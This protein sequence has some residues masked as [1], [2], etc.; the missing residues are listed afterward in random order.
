MKKSG[1]RMRF[2]TDY[3]RVKQRFRNH[4]KYSKSYPEVDIDGGHNLV[5]MKCQFKFKK[6]K[7][8]TK[9]RRDMERLKR[10]ENRLAY[11]STLDTVKKD[12]QHTG[13][14][15]EKWERI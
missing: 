5:M 3:I 1:D 2:Q 11:Q 8:S 14:V 12:E 9:K 13:S 6:I 7:R 15:E 4:V 10:T